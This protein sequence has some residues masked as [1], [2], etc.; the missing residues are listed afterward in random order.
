VYS[1][2]PTMSEILTNQRVDEIRREAARSR[3]AQCRPGRMSEGNVARQ[4]RLGSARKATG[5]A[6][7]EIGLRLAVPRRNRVVEA[8]AALELS[9]AKGQTDFQVAR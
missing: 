9:A 4:G 7:V 6:L 3:A 5:W 1:L 8:G 2:I